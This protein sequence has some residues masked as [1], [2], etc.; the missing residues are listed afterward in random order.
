VIEA[1]SIAQRETGRTLFVHVHPWTKS[2]HALLDRCERAG[3]DLTR[4]VLCHLDAS[5]PD[6][7]YHRSL[8]G[9]GAWV[10]YD[11]FGDDRD[12]YVG[13]R[14]PPD[15]ER[16]RGV[17]R[18]F[19]EGWAD[20]LLV[21]HDIAL[22]TRLWRYGGC[23]YDYLATRIAPRLKSEGLSEQD[24]DLLFARNP[25]RAISHPLD[26]ERAHGIARQND[27]EAA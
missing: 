19:E 27:E 8:A 11:L 25:A 4:V 9:R 5:L 3:A 10:S 1:A 15:S 20:H 23:G 6:T 24:V 26:G 21:S 12:D 7:D 22:K 2:A 14:F 18:A 17:A 16:V 13:R